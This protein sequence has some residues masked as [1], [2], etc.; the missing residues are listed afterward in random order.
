MSNKLR[1]RNDIE[2]VRRWMYALEVG[3]YGTLVWSLILYLLYWLHLSKLSPS[4]ITQFFLKQEILFRWDGILF[5]FIFLSIGSVLVSLLYA[6][7]LSW[8]GSPWLG[9]AL[10]LLLW[11]LLMG[12]R[13]MDWNTFSST[14]TV[15]I[16]YGLFVGYSLSVEFS[17][18]AE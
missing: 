3:F 7:T 13:F 2:R 4:H 16:L 9:V 12:W 17:S 14:L 5:S 6:Y 10:G 15:F 8:I 11:S 1:G 18:P